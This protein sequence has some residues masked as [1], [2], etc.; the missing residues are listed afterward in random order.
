MSD[1]QKV[2]VIGAGLGGLSAAISLQQQ[3]YQ[4]QVFEKNDHLGGKLNRLQKDGFTFDLGPSILTMPHIFEKLFKNS[5]LEMKDFIRIQ[6]LDLEWRSFFPDGTIIDLYG[7]L[8]R[9]AAENPDLDRKH[10]NE[11]R[12][13]LDYAKVL[14]D[15]TE[16]GY[17]SKGLDTAGAVFK[18]HGLISAVRDFDYF[19]TMYDA[20]A[21]YISH[22]N[23]RDMLA[24][25][26]K[27]VG[28]S[29]Y[30]APAVLNMMIYMQH[31][32]GLWY[33]P[34][35]LYGIAEGLR[36]LAE[37][38]GVQI[39]T[40]RRV[41]KLIKD[42]DRQIAAVELE[43]GSKFE[44]DIFVSNM[45]VVP[46]HEQLLDEPEF[47]A[48]YR[49]KFEPACSGLVLHLGVDR[50]Y[51]QLAHHNFFFSE[52]PRAHFDKVF[53][54]HELPDD[55]TLYVVNSSKTDPGQARP[56]HENIKILPHIP[57]LQEKDFSQEDYMKL[58]E[59]VLTKMERMGIADLRSHII[60]E[61]MW[62]PAD[63]KQ[64]YLS[65]RGSIYG[66]VSDKKK[67]HGLKHAKHSRRHSNLYFVGGTVNPGGGMPM[68]TLSGQQVCDMIVN[69]RK[70]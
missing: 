20:I 19:S 40:G 8:E 16:Q 24:Y 34:G 50:H 52:N 5:D 35:G 46:A 12:K 65:D 3:G 15:V 23:L 31:A 32:Q 1:N 6:R 13:F 49:G 29:P 69:D 64:M 62:V 28:S 41:V 58:R 9:M 68:V 30:D 45:E 33:V 56:G 11:Y 70:V 38:S 26:I 47:A 55:P 39:S 4:V 59:I 27:Y 66:V 14:Y 17:F 60:T 42:E 37:L 61:D 25:F 44:A 36:K 22:Q 2:I 48:K 10:I 57:Y 7:D 53:H 63:I 43:D 51:P 21:R 67:N 18:E 54:R